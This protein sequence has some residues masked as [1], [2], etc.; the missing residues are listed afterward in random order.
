MKAGTM[1][2]LMSIPVASPEFSFQYSGSLSRM[3]LSALNSY[4]ETADQMRIKAGVLQTATFEI[5]V[6]SGRAS[7]N[8]RAVYRDL[9]LAAINEHTGSEKGFF[10]A[11]A[12]F[13][14]NTSRSAGP[15]CR[16]NRVR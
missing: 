6:A 11:I 7:G 1:T 4:L 12:S 10:D 8:V 9:T 16:I 13:I 14:A 3:D 5:N 2:V 15:M